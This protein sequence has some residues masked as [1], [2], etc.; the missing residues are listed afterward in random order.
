MNTR[1]GILGGQP[2]YLGR[3]NDS[4]DNNFNLLRF[5]AASLVLFSH[6]YALSTGSAAAEPLRAILGITWGV[7]A[8]DVFFVISG[9]LVTGSLLVRGSLVEF[10]G[11]RFLRIYPGLWVAL[12]LIVVTGACVTTLSIGDF[13]V[14]PETWK[15]VLYN[16]SV[17]KV[18]HTLPGVFED[19]PW[20]RAVNG[21]LWTLPV[22]VKMYAMLAVFWAVARRLAGAATLNFMRL[23]A[24][25]AALA[26]LGYLALV[27]VERGS[28]A[29]KLTYLF[30][31]GALFRLAQDRV[32]L[33]S[34]FAG[35]LLVA[36]LVAA[37]NKTAFAMVYPLC[38]P[39]LVLYLAFVPRG[40]VR[41]FNQVGDY[42]Y[43]IYIYAFP[44]QQLLAFHWKGIAPHEMLFASL[45]CTLMLAFA[46]WNLIEKR[47]LA[48]KHRF[49]AGRNVARLQTESH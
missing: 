14:H 7:V 45:L 38:L 24:V 31:A 35:L 26:L 22:E 46:S 27:M 36:V 10:L 42:S 2:V 1:S 29:I 44:V 16:G 8:V 48:L 18:S 3:C 19:L 21:S 12:L 13:I 47:A 32:R 34:G 37:T 17:L 25:A 11:A 41:E 20:K 4:R 33:S 40:L 15:Y 49:A 28:L 39:Y 23:C 6:S 30:F 9:F 5:V 43:G